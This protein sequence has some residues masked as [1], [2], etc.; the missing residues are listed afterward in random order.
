MLNLLKRGLSPS[1]WSCIIIPAALK[2]QP[3]CLSKS[4]Y[5]FASWVII[6]SYGINLGEWSYSHTFDILNIA[7][8][9]Q[10]F[11][12]LFLCIFQGGR[13]SGVLAPIGQF[14]N[15]ELWMRKT[16]ICF[17]MQLVPGGSPDPEWKR[18]GLCRFYFSLFI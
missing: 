18:S 6:N 9:F 4:Y 1:S 5:T 2:A 17:A 7:W 15:S 12:F 11:S 10:D 8:K 13:E 16:N 14:E 3:I